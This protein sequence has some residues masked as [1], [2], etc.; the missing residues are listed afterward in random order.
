[1]G[2]A[3]AA[4]PFKSVINR[5]AST[6]IPVIGEVIGGN[7]AVMATLLGTPYDPDYTDKIVVIEDIG[8]PPYR[9][10]RMLTHMMNARKFDRAAAVAFGIFERCEK[11][12]PHGPVCLEVIKE[13]MRALDIP[14]VNGLQFGHI[15][16]S[17]TLPFG[18]KARLDFDAMRLKYVEKAVIDR[19]NIGTWE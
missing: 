1:M 7:L 6:E 14:V 19:P 8:E 12:S 18:I 16:E 5:P 10:D 11:Q 9:I 13:R 4:I 2:K 15:D 17:A 3:G